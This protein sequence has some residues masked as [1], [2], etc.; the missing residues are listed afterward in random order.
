MAVTVSIFPER[1]LV[2]L[3]AINQRDPFHPTFVRPEVTH[4]VVLAGA[5]VPEGD[6]VLLPLEPEVLRR[7]SPQSWPRVRS[8]CPNHLT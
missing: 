3:G 6:G 8:T 2:L 1:N 7:V 4:R 5:V